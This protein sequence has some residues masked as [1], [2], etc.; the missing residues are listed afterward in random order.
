MG[1]HFSKHIACKVPHIH[2]RCHIGVS[3]VICT[4]IVRRG[5]F[6]QGNVFVR[7]TVACLD[8]LSQMLE[9]GDRRG[10]NSVIRFYKVLVVAF[11]HVV[12]TVVGSVVEHHHLTATLVIHAASFKNGATHGIGKVVAHKA[13][14]VVTKVKALVPVVHALASF[15][16]RILD[17]GSAIF[18]AHH[19]S[20]GLLAFHTAPATHQGN[21][22][23][24][25]PSLVR[26]LRAVFKVFHVGSHLASV[27]RIRFV[28][29]V[30][31]VMLHVRF[32]TVRLLVILH[33]EA[34][35]HGH[36]H[37]RHI[38]RLTDKVRIRHHILGQE[39]LLERGTTQNHRMVNDQ[40]AIELGRAFGRSGSILGAAHLHSFRKA[41]R[42][43]QDNLV[44]VETALVSAKV[45]LGGNAFVCRTCRIRLLR[46]RLFKV[47]PRT[48]IHNAPAHP[49]RKLRIVHRVANSVIRVNQVD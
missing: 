24:G 31:L 28:R 32:A 17:P 13:V 7:R 22:G 11:T 10:V 3:L 19:D 18:L 1:I 48:A 14:T 5:K 26:A 21:T 12:N 6:Q 47:L 23:I 20:E 45:K 37:H 2:L 30:H 36:C 16:Q 34:R 4:K 9:E 49:R 41:S 43:I 15:E 33:K 46:S 29:S 40:L 35:V 44:I 42:G 8:F 39:A 27:I 38:H 25:F